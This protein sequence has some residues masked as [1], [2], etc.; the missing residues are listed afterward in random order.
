VRARRAEAQPI[1][2][3]RD[4]AVE[5][6][7]RFA[8]ARLQSRIA[9]QAMRPVPSIEGNAQREAVASDTLPHMN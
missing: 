9:H 7:A 4:Q 1:V 8:Q 3:R 6:V 2:H 5:R